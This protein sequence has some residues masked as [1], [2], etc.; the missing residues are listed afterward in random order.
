VDTLGSGL[1]DFKEF[2]MSVVAQGKVQ[3]DERLERAIKSYDPEGRLET[4]SRE[5]KDMLKQIEELDAAT[6]AKIIKDLDRFTKAEIHY[7][8]FLLILKKVFDH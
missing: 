2:Q 6:I 5:I 1:I 7:K 4:H 3:N 8:E